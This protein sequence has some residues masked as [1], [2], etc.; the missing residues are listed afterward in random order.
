MKRKLA[1]LLMAGAVLFSAAGCD[2]G[3]EPIRQPI[4]NTQMPEGLISADS[5]GDLPEEVKENEM[6]LKNRFSS[7]TD[8]VLVTQVGYSRYGYKAVYV[9]STV[10]PGAGA[11]YAPF[12]VVETG[13]NQPVFEGKAI[14][15]GEQWNS[16]WWVAEFTDLQTDGEYYVRIDGGNADLASQNFTIGATV[17]TDASIQ[18]VLFDQLDARRSEGKLGWRDSS[19][20]LLREI[21]A[22]IMAL[23]TLCDVYDSIYGTLSSDNQAKVLDNIQFGCTYLLALQERTDD[24]LTD[25]RFKHD[26]YDTIYSAPKIR[27]F[28]DMVN[29]MATLARCYGIMKDHDAAVAQQYK[30][31]FDVSYKL[32]VLRP[33]YLESEFKL[34]AENGH[35]GVT[36]AAKTRYGI[37]SMLWEFPTTLR[38]RD[39]LMFMRACTEMYKST[40]D[41]S[42]IEQAEVLA[43]QIA[44]RQFTDYQSAIDGCYGMFKEFDNIETAV[45]IDWLQSF[46][47]N[48]GCIQPTDLEPF[49]VLIEHDPAGENTARW[50][51]V[52]H[53]F[54][55]GYVKNSAK[56]TA[57]GIYPIGAYADKEHGGVKFFQSMSHGANNLYGAMGRN[58]TILG[59][60]LNDASL[61]H[62]AQRNAQFIIGLNPGIPNA[63]EVTK[64]TSV[65]FIYGL[66]TNYFTPT[67][68]DAPLGSGING[69]TA[70][71]QF[72]EKDIWD[73]EDLP[74]GILYENGDYQFNEDYL[75]H[76]MAYIGAAVLTEAPY[77]LT[78]CTKT[79]ATVTVQTEKGQI[80]VYETDAQDELILTELPLGQTIMVTAT[81][82]TVTT[83]ST[84]AA[85]GGGSDTWTV[86]FENCL[87]LRISAPGVISGQSQ[88][89]ITMTN[90]GSKA[91]SVDLSVL[92]DGIQIRSN[93]VM[94]ELAPGEEVT[95][96]VDIVSEG[97]TKPYVLMAR[98]VHG[99]LTTT[100]SLE[101][102]AQ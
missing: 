79:A 9:R 44:D 8:S 97:S 47:Q 101:G 62:L 50:Y 80:S 19:T 51:N 88:A 75:P 56:L 77:R 85:V 102:F 20:D 82:G 84:F 72:E 63:Y 32:C 91:I 64:W 41:T 86:D 1:A 71:K 65:S 67:S 36:K 90:A 21:Q 92:C 10:D 58:M 16:Y 43:E 18:M 74:L 22:N 31:A 94:Q 2:Q 59:N 87:R 52:I 42:Y 66:G 57:L 93:A 78:I 89:F 55:E 26:L 14:Y 70:A 95:V 28:Y 48:L 33:Y 3:R 27:N 60:Y 23:E 98:A 12:S 30:D 39:R 68:G 24:P 13:S 29:A 100:V 4:G 15:W 49:M 53:T 61:Q 73:N 76:G 5:W 7:S 17:L 96:T 54:T 45:M 83:Q 38:T 46:G 6:V 81:D 11:Y 99:D 35:G 37:N 40:G 34:E 69:F 25:G